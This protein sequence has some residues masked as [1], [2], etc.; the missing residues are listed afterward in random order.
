MSLE[1]NRR[2][3]NEEFCIGH[4]QREIEFV[5]RIVAMVHAG[6]VDEY[7]AVRQKS[8][9]DAETRMMKYQVQL[10]QSGLRQSE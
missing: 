2:I 6:T 10:L 1:L 4:W 8:I 3:A 5:G 9:T 7:L